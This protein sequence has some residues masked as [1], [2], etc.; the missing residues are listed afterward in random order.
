[1]VTCIDEIKQK[2]LFAKVVERYESISNLTIIEDIPAACKPQYNPLRVRSYQVKPVRDQQYDVQS[3]LTLD[4]KLDILS[5]MEKPEPKPNTYIVPI[6]YYQPERT[7]Q[8][9]I[10]S[11]NQLEAQISAYKRSQDRLKEQS[12][13]FL[14][15]DKEQQP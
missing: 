11:L 7:E 14:P 15:E 6:I 2:N 5:S 12:D 10:F 4:E 8:I 9:D 1:M 3:D 13:E